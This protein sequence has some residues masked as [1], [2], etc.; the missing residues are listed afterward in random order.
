MS[1]KRSFSE[2]IQQKKVRFALAAICAYFAVSS[3]FQ[4]MTG[5]ER[6]DWLRGGGG[7]LLWGS[8]AIINILKPYGRSLP[9][10]NTAVNVG[11]VLVVASWVV[12][13]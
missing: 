9:G 4:L 7:L 13:A 2:F 1:S 12:R 10:I 5:D 6:A 3:L 11:L 8:W